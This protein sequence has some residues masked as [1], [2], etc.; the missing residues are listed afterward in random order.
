MSG[1]CRLRGLFRLRQVCKPGRC[2]FAGH[3][4]FHAG[5]Q[6]LKIAGG[7]GRLRQEISQQFHPARQPHLPRREAQRLQGLGKNAKLQRFA[8][9]Q[10]IQ[11]RAGIAQTV[12]CHP[13][14]DLEVARILGEGCFFHGFED[15]CLRLG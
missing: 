15:N 3:K 6:R 2:F 10:F 13:G 4:S 1:R 8:G 14:E 9:L 7:R 12:R 5:Y 11:N